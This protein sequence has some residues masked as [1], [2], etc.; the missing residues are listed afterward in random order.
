MQHLAN[1]SDPEKSKGKLYYGWVVAVA[2]AVCLLAANN[3][4][5]SFG[6]FL[7]PLISQFGWSRAA[8]SGCVTIRSAVSGIVSPISGSLSDRYGP[9]KLIVAAVSMVA[10]S[11]LLAARIQSLFGLYLALLSI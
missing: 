8:I 3:F 1:H 7:K 9:R 5:Y 4:Q 6:V 11:Y 10:L 2:S